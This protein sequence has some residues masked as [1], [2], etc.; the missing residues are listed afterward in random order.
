MSRCSPLVSVVWLLLG[1]QATAAAAPECTRSEV[2]VSG[3]DGYHTYRIPALVVSRQG[4]VL[5]FCE[6][7]KSSPRDDGDIDLLLK[8]SEDGGR[9]WTRQLIVHEEGGNAPITI[10]NPCPIV[11]VSGLIHLLFTRDN[12]RL[13]YTSSSDD[14]RSWSKPAEHTAILKGYDY[15]LVRIAT[16][17]GHGIQLRSGR[18]VAPIWVCDRERTAKDRNSAAERYRSGVICSDDGGGTWTPGGLVAPDLHCLNESTVLERSDGSLLLNMRGHRIGFRALA[19]SW[20]GGLTW[21]PPRLE[22]SLPCPTCQGSIL[23]TAA[24]EVIFSNPSA[25]TRTNLTVRLSIDQG[26][27]W[28]ASRVLEAGPAGYS[29]LAAIQGGHFLCLY[30]CGTKLYHEKIAIA[31]FSLAWLTQPTTRPTSQP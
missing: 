3:R 9:T 12:H 29:D 22:R 8:R 2:F 25:D 10:G 27:T 30:E 19:E 5:A 11:D 7:R 16:G 26:R 6:G 20:D 18:L 24:G 28:A 31:R 21:S 1:V 17:P 15:P 13:F 14:G 23:S 4:T